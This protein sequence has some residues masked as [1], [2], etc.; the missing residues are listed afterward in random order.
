MH[1]GQVQRRQAALV[2]GIQGN[3]F[4]QQALQARQQHVFVAGGAGFGA[5]AKQ[6]QQRRLAGGIGR[7]GFDVGQQQHV[8]QRQHALAVARGKRVQGR[9]VQ[10]RQPLVVA[11]LGVG[12]V[13]KQARNELGLAQRG[14]QHQRRHFTRQ[15]QVGFGAGAQQAVDH[16][17]VAHADRGRKRRRAGARGNA[18]VGAAAEQLF[19]HRF[20]AAAGR[21][22]QRGAALGVDGVHRQVQ[23][24]QAAHGFGVPGHRGGRQVGRLQG[25]PGQLPLPP[26]QPV[27]QLASL[28][29]QGQAQRR[30]PVR[31]A[32]CR[33]SAVADQQLQRALAAQRRG[34]VQ[35]RVAVAVAVVRVGAGSQQ[36]LG[37][38]Q[39][40]QADGQAQRRVGR[41]AT[42]GVGAALE[43]G[44]R[45]IFV[46][47][48]DVFA[49]QAG[50][51]PARQAT[52]SAHRLAAVEQ[53]LQRRAGQAAA[54]EQ[55]H[56]GAVLVV[57]AGVG[58]GAVAQQPLKHGQVGVAGELQQQRGQ[59]GG[60]GAGAQAQH[61]FGRLQPAGDQG[62]A[63]QFARAFFEAAFGQAFGDAGGQRVGRVE[64]RHQRPAAGAQGV[65]QRAAAVLVALLGVH[66]HGDEMA[67]ELRAGLGFGG[68]HQGV[69]ATFVHRR[70]IRARLR[71]PGQHRGLAVAGG[72]EQGRG[73]LGV[74]GVAVGAGIEQAA[75][76]VGIAGC[77]GHVQRAA[78]AV[79][80]RIHACLVAQQQLHAG[81]IVVAAGRR[82]QGRL[83]VLG[84]GFGAA[85]DQ[86]LGQAPVAAGAGHAQG[87]EA[88]GVERLERGAGVEQQRR[89]R[90]VGAARGVV[91]GGI[92]VGVGVARVGAVGQQGHHRFGPA[93]PAVAGGRQQGRQAGV[94][95]V[96]VDTAGDQVAQQAQVAQQGGQ[97]R[98]AALVAVLRS[99]QGFRVGAVGQGGQGGFDAAGAGGGKQALVR[100]LRVFGRRR[101]RLVFITDDRQVGRQAIARHLGR[102]AEGLHQPVR[103]QRNEH[104]TRD[105][106]GPGQRRQQ[107]GP[108]QAQNGRQHHEHRQRHH[109]AAACVGRTAVAHL[110]RQRG[111]G[112]AAAAGQAEGR[113]GPPQAQQ[114]QAAQRAQAQRGGQGAGFKQGLQRPGHGQPQPGQAQGPER[115]QGAGVAALHRRR[116]VG[117]QP[118]QPRQAQR[119]RG[120]REQRRQRG[121]G[122]AKQQGRGQG[123]AQRQPG[124]GLPG[125]GGVSHRPSGPAR[126]AGTA[127]GNRAPAGWPAPPPGRRGPGGGWRSGRTQARRPARPAA[128][129]PPAAAWKSRPVC[130]GKDRC[131]A[132]AGI[133]KRRL[134]WHR[135]AGLG[136]CRRKRR[137]GKAAHAPAAPAL[138]GLP[139]RFDSR[140]LHATSPCRPCP[141]YRLRPAGA[142]PGTAYAR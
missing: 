65:F 16:A 116:Q 40:A 138:L 50:L 102:L 139:A 69:A 42:E 85:F 72:F 86:E 35:G 1:R 11:F 112:T 118:A 15:R 142:G 63:Q 60:I 119:E 123:G 39:P 77:A 92:A 17:D 107:P 133:C 100:I 90:R 71:Q 49:G 76:H 98:Q 45:E 91:Q 48:A 81:G 59:A 62:F 127:G 57:H 103:Q 121:P 52:A 9:A 128:R 36:G 101:R 53:A 132:C 51:Q 110:G 113:P 32:Q 41:C 120:L 55:V 109:E 89:H 47:A 96:E 124:P 94:F 74:A 46:A 12:A 99:R 20:V 31:R 70:D 88:V 84:F 95:G 108:G 23:F 64:H 30:L 13:G 97:H 14:G 80:A 114:R 10:R 104:E 79:P 5:R 117:A 67:Q 34:G 125:S 24:Q 66:A 82:Q 122:L 7:I 130:A 27:R 28:R 126:W 4:R 129:A 131:R 105:G 141:G 73:A 3:T 78:L 111:Q 137:V 75:G 54:V 136:D 68:Q 33:R 87:A 21:A 106:E 93:V 8:H 19:D 2:G 29:G 115:G 83:A 56:E 18:G 43:Q 58:D 22:Q 44:H 6:Q 37:Q 61:G 38:A 134:A 140:S 25:A 26:F 135:R